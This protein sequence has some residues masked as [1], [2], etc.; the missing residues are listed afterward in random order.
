M[1]GL[2]PNKH[3]I[4]DVLQAMTAKMQSVLQTP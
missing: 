3:T 2:K 1:P 4:L